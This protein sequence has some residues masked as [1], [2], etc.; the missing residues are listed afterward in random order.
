MLR[1]TARLAGRTLI[2]LTAFLFTFYASTIVWAASTH[3]LWR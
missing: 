1:A 2:V 3:H